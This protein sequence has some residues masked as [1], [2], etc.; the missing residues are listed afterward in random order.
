MGLYPWLF[1]FSMGLNPWLFTFNPFR[2]I[3][4]NTT[5]MVNFE[6]PNL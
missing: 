6:L 4:V 5:N 2:I 3:F 1:T